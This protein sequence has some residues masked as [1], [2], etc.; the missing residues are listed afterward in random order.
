[1]VIWSGP[2]EKRPLNRV[3]SELQPVATLA[4]IAAANIFATDFPILGELLIRMTR[5]TLTPTRRITI[6]PAQLHSLQGTFPR[7]GKPCVYG[8]D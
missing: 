2:L 8:D 7:G 3:A 5:S 4:S 6:D 1:M